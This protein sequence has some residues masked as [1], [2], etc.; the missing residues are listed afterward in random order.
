M[1]W[2]LKVVPWQ[3]LM[4]M[5]LFTTPPMTMN[6]IQLLMKKV[7]KTQ[8]VK[9]VKMTQKWK[10]RTVHFY[11]QSSVSKERKNIKNKQPSLFFMSYF[12]RSPMS[13]PTPSLIPLVLQRWWHF[14]AQNLAS[15]LTIGRSLIAWN[16]TDICICMLYILQYTSW[17]HRSE[18]R[19]CTR[20]RWLYKEAN[21]RC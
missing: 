11:P 15:W 16:K 18:I 2:C 7:A 17:I 3:L 20:L 4:R 10:L 12:W 6:L 19:G 1:L 21:S 14:L 5:M 9:I 8:K 13:A